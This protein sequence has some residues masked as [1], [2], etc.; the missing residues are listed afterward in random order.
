MD[1]TQCWFASQQPFGHV[2]AS[3]THCPC[4]LHSWPLAHVAHAA[5]PVP[6]AAALGVVTQFP[7]ASQHPFGHE[8]ASHAHLPCVVLHS[9]P[10]AQD[11][12]AVP[13][14]PQVVFD[15]I[16]HCPVVV[17]QHPAHAPPPH[18]HAPLEQACPLVHA[19]HAAPPVPQEVDD[20][21]V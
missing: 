5:P 15:C 10:E 16:W 3:Q 2:W 20:W 6:H 7:E 12:H 9:W 18:V 4:A 8:V 14:R 19:P 13:F 21:A 1:V 17:S 11:W